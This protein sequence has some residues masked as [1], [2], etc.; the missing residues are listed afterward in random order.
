MTIPGAVRGTVQAEID[1]PAQRWRYETVSGSDYV[2][3]LSFNTPVGAATNKQCGRFVF[4]GMH[5]SDRIDNSD[6]FA[7]DQTYNDVVVNATLAHPYPTAKTAASIAATFP[8]CCANRTA[9]SGPEKALEFMI[10]DLSS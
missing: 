7:S 8:G 5:V 6:S 1:P 9:L 3:F 2:H 10:F 4:T